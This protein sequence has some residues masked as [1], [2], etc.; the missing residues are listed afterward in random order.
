MQEHALRHEVG[1]HGVAAEG[2]D[3][4]PHDGQHLRD[5]RL[6]EPAETAVLPQ[7]T[8]VRPIDGGVQRRDA[9]L[10]DARALSNEEKV[11]MSQVALDSGAR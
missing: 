7:K 9:Y 5:E 10:A 11:E 3:V 8:I 6:H 1:D 4:R 2:R